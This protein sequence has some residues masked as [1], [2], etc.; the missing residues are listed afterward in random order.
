MLPI[1]TILHPTDFSERSEH[2]FHVACSLARDYDARLIV[3]HVLE[4]T[5]VYGELSMPYIAPA[6]QEES[7]RKQLEQ[8]EVANVSVNLEHQLCE[9]IPAEEILKVAEASHAD[10]IVMGTHGRRGLGRILMG[11]VAEEVLRKATCP[12][13]IVKLPKLQTTVA[14]PAETGSRHVT[15]F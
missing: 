9:G 7:A 4:S 8:L 12:V 3:L 1:R 2:A 14:E 11:S 6:G 15:V 5:V 10:M 13:L